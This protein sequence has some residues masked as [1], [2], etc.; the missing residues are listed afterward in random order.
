MYICI[1]STCKSKSYCI[2][3]VDRYSLDIQ[4]FS[5]PIADK[6]IFKMHYFG[7]D[8]ASNVQSN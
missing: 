2:L 4:H 7:S 1:K 5:Y 8:E 6:F 3:Q